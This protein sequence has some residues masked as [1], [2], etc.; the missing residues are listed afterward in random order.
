MLRKSI[1]SYFWF[2]TNIRYLQDVR[3]GYRLGTLDGGGV[4]MNLIAFFA[5]LEEFKL[6]VSRR[7]SEELKE[8]SDELLGKPDDH[9]LTSDEAERLRDA[10]RQV[11]HTLEAELLGFDAYILTPK[12]LDVERLTGKVEDLLAPG[13]FDGLPELARYDLTEAG[14]CIAFERP[15]AAA[16]H[17]LRCTE[18]MVK[19]LYFHLVKRDRKQLMWGPMIA[20]LRTRPRAKQ[21]KDLLNHLDHIRTSFRN[22]TQHPEKRYDIQE[23]QDLW[24]LCVDS[25]SRIA[26]SCSTD[27]V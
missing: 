9:A 2:G 16:F 21:H 18:E 10:M 6:H 8:V 4:R 5:R 15:T 13:I 24:S 12:R 14:K 27:A 1:Y 19:R 3:E 17:L 26:M 20:D 22:P 23:A 7:A 11:R 25:I